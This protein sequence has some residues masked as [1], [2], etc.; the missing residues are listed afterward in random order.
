MA[1][2]RKFLKAL[3]IEGEKAEQ[4]IEA[5]SETVEGLKAQ[6]TEA[7][8]D[9]GKLPEVQRELETAKADLKAVKDDGW[10][11]KHDQL[12]QQFDAY[13]AEISARDSKAAKEGAAR[14]YYQGKGIS[15]KA[16]E[17]AMRGSGPE[18][19]ALELDGDG[20]IRDAGPLD[21]L[22]AGDFSG[23]VSKTRTQGA[24]TDMPPANIGGGMSKAEIYKKD[25]KGR[26]VLDATARQEAL[27]KI[28][29]EERNE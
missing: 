3:E 23:L 6:L 26:Y 21:S 9:A 24:K 16:L 27:T 25:E 2:T 14:A 4:I 19:A 18:I 8:A 12:K 10:K 7:Q 1:L 11:E 28:M 13:K 5:H 20:K 17:V 29:M 22:I 15:G